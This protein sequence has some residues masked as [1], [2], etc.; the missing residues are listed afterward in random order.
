MDRR[1]LLGVIVGVGVLAAIYTQKDAV[2]VQ[3]KKLVNSSL[4][5]IADFESFSAMPYPDA[6]GESVGFGHFIL[7]TDNFTFPMSKNDAYAL[8]D[9]DATTAARAIKNFVVVPLTQNQ[10]DALVSLTYNIGVGAFKESTLLKKLNA[11]D[12]AGAA[13]QFSVWRKSQGKV[14]QVLVDHRAH[15]QEIFLTA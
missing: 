15:E 4:K 9:I 2:I 6:G 11:G 1:A 12:Y 3:A 5:L 8:L 14:M 13:A 10:Y 7:P